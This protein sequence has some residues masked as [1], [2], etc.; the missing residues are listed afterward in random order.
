MTGK[1]C[2]KRKKLNE[3]YA[4]MGDSHRLKNCTLPPFFTLNTYKR[5]A[6]LLGQFISS[7]REF[8]ESIQKLHEFRVGLCK[9]YLLLVLA[10]YRVIQVKYPAKYMT[11]FCTCMVD[12][13]PGLTGVQQY[14][15]GTPLVFYD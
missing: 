9:G 12:C 1:Y 6:K 7:V 13:A 4:I 10:G 11:V 15:A 8:I 5:F 3:S 2:C 14:K